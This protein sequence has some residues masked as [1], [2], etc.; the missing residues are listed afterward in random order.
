[1]LKKRSNQLLTSSSLAFLS[2]KMYKPI[3]SCEELKK[4]E[5][6]GK[7]KEYWNNQPPTVD[8]VLGGYGESNLAD[9]TLSR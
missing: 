7:G 5:W 9:L 6:Y 8:G 1:M 4:E 3:T 2:L